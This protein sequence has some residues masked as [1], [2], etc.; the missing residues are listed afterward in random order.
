MAPEQAAAGMERCCAY[1]DELRR[2]GHFTGGEALQASRNAVT[3]WYRDGKVEVKDGPYART[4]AQLGGILLLEA[5][6][7]NHAIELMS[8][9]PG[10]EFGP[11]EIR[12]ADEQTNQLIRERERRFRSQSLKET[13]LPTPATAQHQ[14]LQQLV[15]DWAVDMEHIG[16][17]GKPSEKSQ[18]SER[19]RTLGE[20]WI[21][22]NGEGDMPCS[23]HV[24]A[25]TTLGYDVSQEKFVGMFVGSMMSMIWHYQGHL[26]AD[27]RKLV[28]D[29]EGPA[30]EDMQVGQFQDTIEIIDRDH[31]T[32]TSR[33][34]RHDGTW[35]EF[36]VARYTRKA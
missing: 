21:V 16:A 19:V 9:H 1:D 34:L 32:M 6:D 11:F 25:S 33:G 17:G 14:W 10:V 2:G 35:V 8:K 18:W 7:L 24:T 31:R 27:G 28:L 26:S 36:M 5:R 13:M 29:T 12:P 30:M 4:E 15:G 23:G 20:L 3:L 22:A